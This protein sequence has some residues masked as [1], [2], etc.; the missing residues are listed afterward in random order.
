MSPLEIRA[1]GPSD[2]EAILALTAQDS[3]HYFDEPSTVTDNQRAA[4]AEI[5]ADP[6]QGLLVGILGDRVVCTAQLT[7]M[8]VL[9]SDGGLYCQVEAVRT[10]TAL[11][12]QGIGRQLMDH[13][14]TEARRRGAARLQLT[15]NKK[16]LRAHEFYQRLGF[17]PSHTGMKKNLR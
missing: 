8:R 11:R 7:W 13:I 9:S 4:L 16:R 17:T 12:G 14:E 6:N 1:A 5:T 15:T 3:M 2:L 10:A